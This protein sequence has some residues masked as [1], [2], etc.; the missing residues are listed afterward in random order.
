MVLLRNYI[1]VN[2]GLVLIFKFCYKRR[3]TWNSHNFLITYVT[4][5]FGNAL[6]LY[7][8]QVYFMIGT[9]QKFPAVLRRVTIHYK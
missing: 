5:T 2:M 8:K 4:E 9:F 1:V 7:N 3:V 6:M